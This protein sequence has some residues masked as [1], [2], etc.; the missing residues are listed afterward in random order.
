VDNLNRRVF[1]F[2]D[3]EELSMGQFAGDVRNEMGSRLLICVQ[4]YVYYNE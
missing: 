3:G 2:K 1:F 4:M